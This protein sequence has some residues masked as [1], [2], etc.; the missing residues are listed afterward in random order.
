HSQ[1]ARTVAELGIYGKGNNGHGRSLHILAT[2]LH[3]EIPGGLNPE[4]YEEN[5][6]QARPGSVDS[7][8]AINYQNLLVGGRLYGPI[9]NGTLRH[10]TGIYASANLFD[11][12]FNI[13][14][15]RE[16]NL[17]VGL[18][19]V[20]KHEKTV[21]GLGQLELAGGMEIQLAHKAAR[22]YTPNEGSPG[23]LNFID[24]VDT[25]QVLFFVN[26]DLVLPNHWTFTIGLSGQQLRYQVDRTFDVEG[27]PGLLNSSFSWVIAPRISVAK[28]W[29]TG[30]VQYAAFAAYGRAYSPPTLSEFRTNEGSV[31]TDLE[32]AQG[33]S[34]EI[35]FRRQS[36]TGFN[37]DLNV[38]VQR[39]GQ[40]ITTFQDASGVQLFRNAG[41]NNQFGVELAISRELLPTRKFAEHFINRLLVRVAYTLQNGTY[42]DYRPNDDD[43][44]GQDL[45]GLTPHIFDVQ[46]TL[47]TKQNHYLRLGLHTSAET[48]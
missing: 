12:P 43:F 33:N 8:A 41:G 42:R 30:E 1:L 7:R 16:S 18:R 36:P 14:H 22:N 37:V 34:Y 26:G 31:N 45:P 27:S 5:P 4:Q 6:R 17:G 21:R 15:K 40:S 2:D 39:L 35:G 13:D 20:L 11:H 48:P 29:F 24:D 10:E 46:L 32:P 47:E 19:S 28:K 44:S 25:H 23:E 38:Y 9:L 3:Y